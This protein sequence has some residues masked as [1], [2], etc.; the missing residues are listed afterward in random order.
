MINRDRIE[1][2]TKVMAESK[3]RSEKFVQDIR[4]IESEREMNLLAAGYMCGFVD[5]T[6]EK[7]NGQ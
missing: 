3:M 6:L 5:G 4:R 7:E 1:R 2:I